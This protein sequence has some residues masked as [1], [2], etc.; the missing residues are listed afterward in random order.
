MVIN[1]FIFIFIFLTITFSA[2]S[3]PIIGALSG[4]DASALSEQCWNNSSTKTFRPQKK[5]TNSKDNFVIKS[6][7]STTQKN[8]LVIVVGN[9]PQF[10]KMAPVIEELNRKSL[11]YTVIHTG[12][13]YDHQMSGIFF[14]ELGI[15][16]P[17][18]QIQLNSRL[19]GA[20]TAEIL[21][22]LES[23][24]LEIVL[25]G[26]VLF[27]ILLIHSGYGFS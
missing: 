13:H 11:K 16:K 7:M 22:K 27:C 6:T 12:Q 15:P 18:I 9:R 2:N 8:N 21:E 3:I 26:K 17:D 19:H 23:I 20:M 1:Y 25:L 14:K 4:V 24:F 5:L 10:I